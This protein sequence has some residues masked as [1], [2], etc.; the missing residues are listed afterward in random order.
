MNEPLQQ[1][2]AD[3]AA[4]ADLDS[5]RGKRADEGGKWSQDVF[6]VRSD[7]QVINGWSIVALILTVLSSFA[8]VLPIFLGLP[9]LAIIV[10]L[11]ALSRIRREPHLF[12]GRRLA[13]LSLVAAVILGSWS[14]GRRMFFHAH[15]YTAAE[16]NVTEWFQL[17]KKGKHEAAHQ[18]SLLPGMRAS[19]KTTLREYYLNEKRAREEMQDYFS[20]PALRTIISLGE[21]WSVRLVENRRLNITDDARLL[22]YQR[23]MIEYV[24]D[25]RPVALA[26]ETK[27]SRMLD[28]YTRVSHWTVLT[29]RALE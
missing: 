16:E 1:A 28:K 14:I 22:V 3:K 24:K 4:A 8:L 6:S 11:F 13:I 7:Y 9:V 18:L 19:G 2:D 12:M 21:K 25:G 17:L 15:M 23:F 10:S 5:Q 27:S 26:V 20:E 29:V